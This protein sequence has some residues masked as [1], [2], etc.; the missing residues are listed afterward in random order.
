ML[1]GILHDSTN[2]GSDAEILSAFVAPMSV[3][4]N[5]PSYVQDSLNLKRKASSQNIQRWEIEARLMPT[6]SNA[7]LFVHNIMNGANNVFLIRMPQV[8]GIALT[9]TNRS[10]G[11][12]AIAGASLV[13]VN[14]TLQKGEFIRFANHSKVYIVV[15]P[16]NGGKVQISPSLKRDVPLNTVVQCGNRVTLEA[17]YDTDTR[18]GI[19]YTDGVLSDPGVV[20]F[21]EAL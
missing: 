10:V 5:Q 11:I 6:N 16:D 8:Y 3:F 15:N 9:P 17:R 1:Y 4:S 18:L 19:T 20:T 14:G 12:A 2:T 13:S 21:V 7:D